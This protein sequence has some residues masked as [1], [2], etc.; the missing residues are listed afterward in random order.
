MDLDKLLKNLLAQKKELT[1]SLEVCC[2]SIGFWEERAEKIFKK[3]D[4]FEEEALFSS[5]ESHDKKFKKLQRES[6]K[7]MKRVEFENNQLDLLEAQ[8]LDLEEKIITTLARYAK[9][10]KK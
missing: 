7:I 1:H 6:G 8:V 10:Q 3:M 2:N 4:E 9:K 5:G